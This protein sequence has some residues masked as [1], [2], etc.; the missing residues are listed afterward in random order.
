[1]SINQAVMT[2][3]KEIGVPVRFQTYTGTA[4]SYI[5]FFTYLE[6]PEQH[7]DDEERIT[8]YYVQVDVWSKGNYTDLVNAVHEKML[9]AGFIKQNFYD[10]YEDYLKIYHKAMRF[11]KEVL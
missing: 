6:K 8:G 1:M 2:A 9:A 5:T 10:L 4:D 7:A 3:L 11:F